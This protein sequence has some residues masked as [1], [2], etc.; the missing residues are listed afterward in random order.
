MTSA[1]ITNFIVFLQMYK[2]IGD[3]ACQKCSTDM[4]VY[5]LQVESF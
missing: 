5:C 4:G 1:G 2:L 3:E